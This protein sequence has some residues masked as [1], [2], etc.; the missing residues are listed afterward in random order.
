M[1]KRVF[2]ATPLLL[3]LLTNS[4]CSWFRVK[5]TTK[6]PVNQRALPARAASLQE[7]IQLL[8]SRAQTIQTLNLSVVFELTGGSSDTGEIANYQRTKGFVLVKKP[9]FIRIIVL[10]FNVRLLDMK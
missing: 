7:L 4:Q 9:N 1:L 5:T 2:A 10:A 3:L 6:V 8:N